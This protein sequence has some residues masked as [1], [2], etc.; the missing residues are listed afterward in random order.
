MGCSEAQ[1]LLS[2]SRGTI[3]S[4]DGSDQILVRKTYADEMPSHM[5]KLPQLV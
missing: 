5:A 4:K 2:S 3:D 1:A